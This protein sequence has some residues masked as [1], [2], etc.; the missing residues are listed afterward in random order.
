MVPRKIKLR[1]SG[2]SASDT[3]ESVPETV[4]RLSQRRRPEAGRFLLQVD[5]QTK[6][7]YATAESAVAA[8]M[9]IKT[10]HP[11]VQVTVYDSVEFQSTVVEVPPASS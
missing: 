11:I 3:S 7:S 9:I 5:R 4:E 6:G 8:G 1:E 2:D 10:G